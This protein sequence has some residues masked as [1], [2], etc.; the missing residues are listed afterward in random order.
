MIIKTANQ[1]ISI[2]A[3]PAGKRGTT[4]VDLMFATFLL[5]M[6]GVIFAATFP[7]GITCTRRARDIK[8]ATAIAQRKVEQFRAINYESL[9]GPLLLSAGLIDNETDS[10]GYSFTSVDGVAS[11]LTNGT[12]NVVITEKSSD[13]KQVVVTVSW[14]ESASGS[15][16]NVI[17]RTYIT[18]KRTRAAP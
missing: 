12:G 7:T 5:A 15:A 11:N 14:T 4:L 1:R 6:A 17:L 10:N 2:R 3:I 8:N 18:D 16:R 9:S 13:M